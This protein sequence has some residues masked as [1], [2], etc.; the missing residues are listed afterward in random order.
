MYHLEANDKVYII[1]EKSNIDG[2]YLIT[3]FN[4]PLNYKKMMSITAI[5]SIDAIT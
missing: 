3:K 1:D 5:K 2:E 4:I